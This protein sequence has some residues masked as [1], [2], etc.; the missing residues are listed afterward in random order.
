M[1]INLVMV[2]SAMVVGAVVGG[3]ALADDDN[4]RAR[5]EL[6]EDIDEAIEDAG[7]ELSGFESDSDDSDLGDALSYLNTV[8]S[9]VDKLD[10]V[11]DSDYAAAE[12]VC[13]RLGLGEK[14]PDVEKA[15]DDL[16]KYTTSTK[17]TVTQL[18]KDYNAWLKEVRKL[19]A[20]TDKDHEEIRDETLRIADD[21]VY[22]DFCSGTVKDELGDVFPELSSDI[23]ES[24]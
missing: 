9:L 22:Y 11:K 20:L 6:I 17:D 16:A 21:V 19:R 1:R 7:D 18:K 4:E 13:P 23:S 8:E 10:D 5:K 24:E 15:L 3:M 14:H 12:R 2:G